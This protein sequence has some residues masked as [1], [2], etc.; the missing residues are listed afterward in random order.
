MQKSSNNW[1]EH[2]A[3]MQCVHRAS[4]K[5]ATNV[6]TYRRPKPAGWILISS[7]RIKTASLR[8]R[9]NIPT[10]FWGN[11]LWSEAGREA[12]FG[13]E[14]CTIGNAWNGSGATMEKTCCINHSVKWGLGN[15][16]AFLFSWRC[17]SYERNC[18]QRQRRPEV[19]LRRSQSGLEVQVKFSSFS[20]LK[21]PFIAFIATSVPLLENKLISF[22]WEKMMEKI[23]SRN[24]DSPFSVNI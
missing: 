9:W 7:V 5:L 15:F 14:E 3:F 11:I 23:I 20:S 22:A 13:S 8:N 19:Q 2:V 12:K 10:D 4:P 1:H 16:L 17:F 18:L 24:K 21:F 6:T